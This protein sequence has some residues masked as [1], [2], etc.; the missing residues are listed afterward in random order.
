MKTQEQ[1]Y[2]SK[3]IYT[4]YKHIAPNGKVYI[5]ITCKNPKQRWRNGKGYHHNAHFTSAIQKYGWDNIKHEILFTGLTKEEAEQKEIELIAFYH[6]N[7]RQYGY[8][9]SIGGE[10]SAL[11]YKLSDEQRKAISL[12]MQNR[13]LS[14]AQKER[15]R[16]LRKGVANSPETRKK[17]SESRKGM[18]HSSE[19]VNKIAQANKGKKRSEEF[20]KSKCKAIVQMDLKSNVIRQFDSASAAASAVGAS[21]KSIS[22]CAL[23]Y[24]KTC[25][26]YRW[27]YV[28]D[29]ASVLQVETVGS[30]QESHH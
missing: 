30:I 28:N 29:T 17:M 12:R 13:T 11:G 24:S 26:G 10:H 21:V 2:K 16:Q 9:Q 3:Q 18:K 8:N 19:W 14:E 1:F 6:S 23:G 15:L 7:D 25:K 27:Q 22:A 5:G 20:C 4:V